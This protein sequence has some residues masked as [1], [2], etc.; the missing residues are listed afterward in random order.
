VGA[1]SYRYMFYG[2]TALTTPPP[3]L[4]A[5][6][7][8]VAYAYQYMFSGCSN[9]ETAPAIGLSSAPTGSQCMQYMF[10]GCSKLNKINV[11]LT[12]WP[13]TGI[14]D[15]WVDGV[16]S[17]GSFICPAALGTDGTI[18]RGSSRCP[19][20]WSVTNHNYLTFT[21]NTAGSTVSMSAV[22]SA[23]SVALKTST[24]QGQT[25]QPFVVGSTTITLANAGDKVYF[26][27]DGSNAKT[28]SSNTAYNK[29]VMTGR[30]AA[31]NGVMS[32][33]DGTGNGT[34]IPSSYCFS[35]LF[36][37]CTA[38]I[39]APGLPA[40][41]LATYCYYYMFNGCASLTAA[42]ELPATTLANYCY[43]YMFQDCTSLTT[44]P[45]LPATTLATYCY[46]YMFQ[47]CT[48]LTTAPALPATSLTA[49]CY[50]NMFYGCSALTTPP[51]SLPATSD[52]ATYAYQYMFYG[53]SSLEKSP[54]ISLSVT[55]SSTQMMRYMFQNC[56]NLKEIEI[57]IPSWPST[58][59]IMGDWV[60][61]VAASGTFKCPAALGT[62]STIT[63]GTSNCPTG[64]TVVNI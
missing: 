12:S 11:F 37:G 58:A 22:G 1:S 43:R 10:Q 44:A 53:C 21:A 5:T 64:W 35:H 54:V 17:A 51:P 18:E 63:R 55:P 61:G 48:S 59:T 6:S 28:G 15:D 40:T 57:H 14:M 7:L 25:W 23:P 42:P 2:C 36:D 60:N 24:D 3:S 13:T 20:G 4:P 38:L 46:Q 27:A 39:T 45:A 47:G 19:A 62:N 29:F 31:S 34:E 52:T 32:I 50:R 30:I 26:A 16:A 8:S 33:I 49:S 41:T 9:L 56:S